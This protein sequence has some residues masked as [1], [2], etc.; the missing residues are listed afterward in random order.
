MLV[1]MTKRRDDVKLKVLVELVKDKLRVNKAFSKAL[2]GYQIKKALKSL[3][4]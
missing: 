1:M 3:K 4:I 2:L